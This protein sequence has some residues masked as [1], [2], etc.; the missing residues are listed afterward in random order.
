MDHLVEQSRQEVRVRPA[1]HELLCEL[2]SD[3]RTQPAMPTRHTGIAPW[4]LRDGEV[5]IAGE[6]AAEEF[7]V[8]MVEDL[9][10]E[11]GAA[12]QVLRA[13]FQGLDCDAEV[14]RVSQTGDQKLRCY[15][16]LQT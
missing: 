2:D 10:G 15:F 5:H 12:V 16:G 9:E 8:Q 1:I 6:G 3:S 7:L 4:Q 11:V 13:R 14:L